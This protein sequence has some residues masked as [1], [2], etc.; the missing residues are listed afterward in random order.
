VTGPLR[1]EKLLHQTKR[2]APTTSH[3]W[4]DKGYTGAPIADA[5]AKAAVSIDGVTGPK[6]GHGFI[7]QPAGG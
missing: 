4:L 7:V 1:S 2:I 6:R 5:A 3:V